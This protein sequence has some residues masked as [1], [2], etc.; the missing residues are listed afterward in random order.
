MKKLF[1]LLA[2]CTVSC[3]AAEVNLIPEPFKGWWNPPVSKIT[4]ADGILTITANPDAKANIYQKTQARLAVKGA[5]VQNKKFEFSFK[6][7][8]SKFSRALQAAIRQVL[9]K[10]GIYHGFNLKKW[11][12]SKDWKECKVVFTTRKDAKEL[13]LYLVGRYMKEGE[14]VEIKDLKLIAR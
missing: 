12:V 9:N 2:F 13:H 6:Y 14:K 5:D 10:G 4:F 1:A 7:R 11:D 8:T 3:F